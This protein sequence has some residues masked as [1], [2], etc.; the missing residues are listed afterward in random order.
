MTTKK[1]GKEYKTA[2]LLFGHFRTGEITSGSLLR[3]VVKPNDADIF[4]FGP[5][6]TDKPNR[7]HDG[8]LDSLG[9]IKNNPKNQEKVNRDFEVTE[10]YLKGVY[11]DCL[12]K[13]GFHDLEYSY[14]QELTSD[15][16][17]HLWLYDLEPARFISMFYNVQGACELLKRTEESLGTSY[18]RVIITRPDLAFYSTIDRKFVGKNNLY[19]PAGV[20]YCPYTGNQNIG[21]TSPLFY[22]NANTGQSIRSGQ[23]FNDQLLLLS[24]EN[25]DLF[26]NLVDHV[27]IYMKEGVP[28]TPETLLF[29]HLVTNGGLKIKTMPNWEYEIFRADDSVVKSILDLVLLYK[30]DRYHPRVIERIKNEPI[31]YKVR[32]LKEKL[33]RYFRRWF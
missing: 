16:P 31:K 27:L 21:L 33:Q 19:I 26:F 13:S 10:Q 17:K 8:I 3:H 6:Y 18:D 15:I 1:S 14:F 9:Y 5:R 4:Y 2:I 22:K 25:L 12:L 23:K 30:I 20:G 28:L 32:F 7:T 11:G 29:F 24:R